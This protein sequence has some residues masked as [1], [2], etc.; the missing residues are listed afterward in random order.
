MA[1]KVNLSFDELNQMSLQEF[2]DYIDMWVG[3]EDAT[4]EAE[5]S[6]IDKF[7]SSM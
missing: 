3:D 5:Q 2:F 4:R 1:K 6:D 7:Y